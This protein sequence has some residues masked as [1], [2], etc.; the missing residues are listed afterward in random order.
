MYVFYL[1]LLYTVVQ[2]LKKYMISLWRSWKKGNNKNAA[3]L[4]KRGGVG[5][6][7][8]TVTLTINIWYWIP[9]NSISVYTLF[10]NEMSNFIRM[11]ALLNL[12]VAPNVPIVF[13]RD[14]KYP[15]RSLCIHQQGTSYDPS[16]WGRTTQQ[17]ISKLGWFLMLKRIRS[18][19]H[20]IKCH[21]R[22]VLPVSM[23]KCVQMTRGLIR[24][25]MTIVTLEIYCSTKDANTQTLDVKTTCLFIR[26]MC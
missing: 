12:K 23:P 5:R 2:K 8:S 14:V 13:E 19:M 25:N 3:K 22:Y 16:P 20:M 11:K 18:K 26:E 15:N 17:N 7:W 4:Y 1:L 6:L 21:W 24:S 9:M 10:L